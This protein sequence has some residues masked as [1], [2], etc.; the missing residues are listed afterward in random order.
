[1]D[2]VDGD[3]KSPSKEIPEEIEILTANKTSI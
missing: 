1:M 2:S 3:Q